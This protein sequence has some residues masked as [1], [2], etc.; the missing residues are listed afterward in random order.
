MK[1]EKLTKQFGLGIECDLTPNSL[2]S[3]GSS[4]NECV[5]LHS[6][7]SVGAV[8]F[9][10]VCCNVMSDEPEVGFNEQVEEI[11]KH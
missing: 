6:S 7:Y 3:S 2:M 1:L 11:L 9:N 5:E 8:H 10:N 4:S